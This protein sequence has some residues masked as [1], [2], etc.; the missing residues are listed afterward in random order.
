MGKVFTPTTQEQ[1]CDLMCD[2]IPP[3]T[4]EL[5]INDLSTIGLVLKERRKMLH[6][7]VDEISKQS[8]IHVNTI[9]HIEK[10]GGIP[11]L[12]GLKLWCSVLGYTKITIMTK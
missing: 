6:I 1:L 2:N 9:W 10:G 7:T 11:R 8:G 5:V 12:D 3:P 4:T